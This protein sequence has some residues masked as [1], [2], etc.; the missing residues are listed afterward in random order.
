MHRGT[1][2][3]ALKLSEQTGER[4]LTATILA[5]LGNTF[6]VLGK[7]EPAT[8]HLTKALTLAGRRKPVLVAGI[9]NDLGNAL[10]ARRQFAERS[11]SM[12]KAEPLPPKPNSR[13]WQPRHRSMAPWP[14]C[15]INNWAK[16]TAI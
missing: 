2:Q 6:H 5:Q 4:G 10:T 15:R 16:R 14:C 13:R 8:E 9:L 7:D 3:A 1:L 11:T 12:R